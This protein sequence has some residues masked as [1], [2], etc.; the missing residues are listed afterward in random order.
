MILLISS[1]DLKISSFYFI[2]YL[3]SSKQNFT[4]ATNFI[5]TTCRTYKETLIIDENLFEKD[6]EKVI[7]SLITELEKMRDIEF[8]AHI[9]KLLNSANVIND[10]F[11]KVI[12]NAENI[13]IKNNRIA[14][15]QKLNSLCKEMLSI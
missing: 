11:D 10:Y 14:T 13:E 1:Q 9:E 6:E 15:L 5:F 4:T 3:Y 7:Y 12:I 8:E 2:K